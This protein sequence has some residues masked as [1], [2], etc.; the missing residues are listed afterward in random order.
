MKR[1]KTNDHY[2]SWCVQYDCGQD[3]RTCNYAIEDTDSVERTGTDEDGN[4]VYRKTYLHYPRP[5]C[6]ARKEKP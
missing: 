5:D 6:P 2:P 3:R 4:P 1:R